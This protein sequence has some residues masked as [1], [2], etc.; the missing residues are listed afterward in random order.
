MYKK[1]SDIP[2]GLPG[3]KPALWDNLLLKATHK[4][5]YTE[6]AH[7]FDYLAQI[8]DSHSPRINFS[9]ISKDNSNS[10]CK[11]LY[12]RLIFSMPSKVTLNSSVVAAT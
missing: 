9:L 11:S 1:H 10:F 7:L 3:P 12:K 4:G 5:E 8:T 2:D 6:H